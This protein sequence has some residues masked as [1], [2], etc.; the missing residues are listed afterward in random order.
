MVLYPLITIPQDSFCSAIAG[1]LLLRELSSIPSPF[2]LFTSYSELPIPPRTAAHLFLD[3]LHL[4]MQ[5]VL[6]FHTLPPSPHFFPSFLLSLPTLQPPL[7][8]LPP[9][10]RS[11][12]WMCLRFRTRREGRGGHWNAAH[13]PTSSSTLPSS[14][15]LSVP[16]LALSLVSV[17]FSLSSF[18]F[19]VFVY[20]LPCCHCHVCSQANTTCVR[21]V[22]PVTSSDARPAFVTHSRPRATFDFD[23]FC[24]AMLSIQG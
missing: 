18:S 20:V 19:P 17:F 4:F 22:R 21:I 3:S 16:S 23:T 12:A 8:A 9:D 24:P 11:F 15:L 10:S 14:D 13:L 6:A 2:L 1:Y 7:H 5:P